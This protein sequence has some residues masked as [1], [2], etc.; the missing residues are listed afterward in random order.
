MLPVFDSDSDDYEPVYGLAQEFPLPDVPAPMQL[1]ETGNSSYL[2][3]K[4]VY[5]V[6]LSLL[7]AMITVLCPLLDIISGIFS[8]KVNNF[9][10]IIL[11]FTF[12]PKPICMLHV[13]ANVTGR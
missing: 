3:L 7:H 5:K 1:V 2:R 13:D 11:L 4:I 8:C 6:L 10:F 9:F 12:E